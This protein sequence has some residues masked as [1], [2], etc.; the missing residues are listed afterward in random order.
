M[1]VANWN[2]MPLIKLHCTLTSPYFIMLLCLMP[3]DFTRQGR[4]LALNGLIYALEMMIFWK[5]P[6]ILMPNICFEH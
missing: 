4:E 2:D 3:D 1:H 5:C 6:N